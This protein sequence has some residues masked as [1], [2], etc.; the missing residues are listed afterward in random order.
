MRKG[1]FDFKR[2][3]MKATGAASGG[4]VAL[5]SN[6]VL[7]KFDPKIR[8]IAKIAAGAIL[9]ELAPKSSFVNDMGCG[10]IGAGAAELTSVLVPALAVEKVEGI[11]TDRG[12]V[13][14]EEY[15]LSGVGAP[16]AQ[17]DSPVVGTVEDEVEAW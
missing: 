16:G 4:A 10:M 14:D 8:A 15:D 17:A 9:P 13:I 1:K 6:K 7:G 3:A 12:Y 11:G 5:A 2:I